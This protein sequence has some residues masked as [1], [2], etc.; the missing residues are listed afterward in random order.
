MDHVRAL[1]AYLQQRRRWAGT[2][3]GPERPR[4]I[5]PAA[6]QE[7]TLGRWVHT[8]REAEFVLSLA[9]SYLGP[10]PLPVTQTQAFQREPQV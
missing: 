3:P 8:G 1:S 2:S 10:L 9:P 4:F 7:G 5:W 6:F